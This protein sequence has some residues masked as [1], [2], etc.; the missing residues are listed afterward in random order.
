MSYTAALAHRRRKQPLGCA[1]TGAPMAG[2]GQTT[3]PGPA[4]PVNGIADLSADIKSLTQRAIATFGGQSPFSK[5]AFDLLRQKIQTQGGNL[6]T[7]SRD[8]LKQFVGGTI[9]Q[10]ADAVV[11]AKQL[12]TLT[13]NTAAERDANQAAQSAL[14]LPA[15]TMFNS[16][17][18]V[19]RNMTPL[20]SMPSGTHGLGQVETAVIIAAVVVA[21]LLG[22]AAITAISYWLDSSKR[23]EYASQQAEAICRTATPPCS[24]SQRAQLQH[25]LAL[26]PFD[27]AASNFTNVVGGGIGDAIRYT[28]IIGGSAVGLFLF[29]KFTPWGKAAIGKLTGRTAS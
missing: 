27:A 6:T 20:T 9:G 21:V 2:L 3:T 26:G 8:E 4:G 22:A 14:V 12:A 1:C 25:D 17:S 10:V 23:L 24:A 11:R 7:L 13:V 18:E 19:L 15:R 28:A 29:F 5:S 16:A